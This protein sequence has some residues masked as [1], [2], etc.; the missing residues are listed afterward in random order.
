[1]RRIYSKEVHEFVKENSK[2]LHDR[3]L[4]A[5]CNKALGTNFTETSMKSFR[6]NHRY[7]NGRAKYRKEVYW[8]YQTRYPEGMYEY[9][10]DNSEGVS[11]SR[12]AEMC[13]AKFG[14][15]W[16]TSGMKQFRKRHGIQSGLNGHFN[17]GNRS[18]NKGKKQ[19][20]FMTEEGIERTKATR[21]KK[22]DRAKNE[23]PIGAITINK[24]GY[25]L[26]KKQMDGTWAERWEFLHRAVWEENN[27]PIPKGMVIT[28]KDGNKENCDISNLM[29]ITKAENGMMTRRGLRSDNPEITE[30]GLNVARLKSRIKEI[31]NKRSEN[32]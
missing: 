29:M 26:R 5:E 14:T 3:D 13:N 21:F 7:Y 4:A 6:S 27:G 9:I 22:G 8:K 18:W 28:F 1:M 20:E 10:R 31:K 25:Y 32:E 2:K 15:K 11:A 12:M 23:L 19:S 16:T 30:A 24:D 17:K